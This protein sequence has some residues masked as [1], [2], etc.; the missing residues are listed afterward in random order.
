MILDPQFKD[1]WLIHHDVPE[2]LIEQVTVGVDLSGGGDEV[3][4]VASALLNDGRFAGTG[5]RST[6]GSPAQWGE[7]VVRCHDDFDTDD[8]V[9]EVNFGGDMATE[10]VKQAAERV[11]R[12]PFASG[13]GAA[14]VIPEPGKAPARKLGATHSVLDVTMAQIALDSARVP[15][16]IGELVAASV[17]EY[18]R[19]HGN[20]E[21]D[22]RGGISHE[23]VP[24]LEARTQPELLRIFLA[25]WSRPLSSAWNW[26]RLAISKRALRARVVGAVRRH[27]LAI[28]RTSTEQRRREARLKRAPRKT[29]RNGRSGRCP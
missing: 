24:R 8:V 6:S 22:A 27:S 11:W 17:P 14:L 20:R 29:P 21:G 9:V 7:S 3:G 23:S 1:N 10:V 25:G 26:P 18:V 19:T 28:T 4:I 13:F 16:V 5:R 2:D 12:A 15:P